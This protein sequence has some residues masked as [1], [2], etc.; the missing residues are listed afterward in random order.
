MYL[1]MEDKSD[2]VKCQIYD[3]EYN[4]ESAKAI[5][6]HFNAKIEW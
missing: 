3:P 1:H 5:K 6:M 2:K 4:L